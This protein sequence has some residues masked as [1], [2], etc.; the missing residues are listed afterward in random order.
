M[1]KSLVM[2]FLNEAGKKVSLRIKGIKDGLEDNEVSKVM[3]K[4]IESNIFYSSGGSFKIKSS[5]QIETKTIKK[6]N[7]K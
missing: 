1:D 7:I 3:D 4:V 2:Y 5:A 6:L